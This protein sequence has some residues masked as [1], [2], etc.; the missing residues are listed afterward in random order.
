MVIT[1]SMW[2]T[3]LRASTRLKIRA[4]DDCNDAWYV[5]KQDHNPFASVT[6]LANIMYI[7]TR[8]EQIFVGR[9]G[10]GT[11]DSVAQQTFK[12]KKNSCLDP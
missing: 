12:V 11:R 10:K 8:S 3:A 7:T 2:Y 6:G 1:L 4:H 9:G 5:Q